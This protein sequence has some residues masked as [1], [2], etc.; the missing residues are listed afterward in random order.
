V[1]LQ[2]AGMASSF[3]TVQDLIEVVLKL[4]R[5]PGYVL[6]GDE[7]VV[8][9]RRTRTG[10]VIERAGSD[11]ALAVHELLRFGLLRRGG[12]HQVSFGRYETRGRSVLVPDSTRA[13]SQQ[14]D[15]HT[16]A[17]NR[18]TDAV[19]TAAFVCQVVAVVAPHRGSFPSAVPSKRA[20]GLPRSP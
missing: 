18:V 13:L 14:L 4:A 9:R 20:T 15:S 3:G 6:L 2:V 16:S 7:E 12:F 11:E 1:N 10:P 5:E 8:W 17:V 19:L